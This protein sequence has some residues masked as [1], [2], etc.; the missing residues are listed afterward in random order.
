MGRWLRASWLDINGCMVQLLLPCLKAVAPLDEMDVRADY[1][2]LLNS[3]ARLMAYVQSS[4][5]HVFWPV[6]DRQ[7]RLA[8]DDLITF[9]LRARRFISA[10]SLVSLAHNVLVPI[11][12]LKV[13]RFQDMWRIITT[14]IHYTDLTI[15]RTTHDFLLSN[16]L[17]RGRITWRDAIRDASAKPVGPIIFV[18]SD[19]HVLCLDALALLRIFNEKILCPAVASCRDRGV[20]L[21]DIEQHVDLILDCLELQKRGP[22]FIDLLPST[23]S[24]RYL[25]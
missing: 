5:Q 7:D 2:A 11:G 15:F 6:V 3:C 24:S 10:T 16:K 1:E 21:T 4:P 17:L 13:G 23:L 22:P 8:E 12:P 9:A 18:I 19:Q 14:I 25:S 20:E